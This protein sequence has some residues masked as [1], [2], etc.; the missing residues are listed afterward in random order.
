MVSVILSFAL[1]KQIHKMAHSTYL[2]I[3]QTILWSFYYFFF[4]NGQNSAS[5]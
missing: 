5:I 1:K 4:L 2:K 3:F